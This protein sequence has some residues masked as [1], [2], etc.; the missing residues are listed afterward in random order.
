MANLTFQM[1][2]ILF[3]DKFIGLRQDNF[4]FGLLDLFLFIDVFKVI[5]TSR[6]A[7][8]FTHFLSV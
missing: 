2:R 8:P 1:T 6:S 7:T 4:L 5:L 3:V